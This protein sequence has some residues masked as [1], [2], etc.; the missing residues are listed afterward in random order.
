M[1]TEA[2]FV[3]NS[4]EL[5]K[6]YAGKSFSEIPVSGGS[7]RLDSSLTGGGNI[8]RSKGKEGVNAVSEAIVCSLRSIFNLEKE[9]IHHRFGCSYHRTTYTRSIENWC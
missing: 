8:E 4:L 6:G 7:K 2:S 9:A 3:Q 1:K 5:S